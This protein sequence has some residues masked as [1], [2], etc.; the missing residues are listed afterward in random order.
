MQRANFSGDTVTL[1]RDDHSSDAH[2]APQ[3]SEALSSVHPPANSDGAPR[4]PETSQPSL[5]PEAGPALKRKFLAM[6]FWI[7]IGVVTIATVGLV[8]AAFLT[9]NLIQDAAEA[10]KSAEAK[11]TTAFQDYGEALKNYDS[12]AEDAANTIKDL[13]ATDLGTDDTVG[14]TRLSAAERNI[15]GADEVGKVPDHKRLTFETASNEELEAETKRLHLTVKSLESGEWRYEQAT[16]TLTQAK[17]E[18]A[19]VEAKARAAAELAAKKAAAQPVAYED[20]FRAGES[21]R[22][23][24][25]VF[26]GKIIQ[27]AGSGTYRVSITQ[28]PG[29]SRVFWEDPILV[30]VTGTPSQRLLEDDLIYFV[31]LSMGVESYKSV[32][33]QEISLPLV[34]TT[35]TE[36][37][38]TGRDG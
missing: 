37:T 28:K 22:G 23:N 29:Y 13:T 17:A 31:G 21:A 36:I 27:D 38:I 20:L 10:R 26:E 2:S 1:D 4:S 3:D 35:G 8:F 11:Y 14:Q 7:G 34:S 9:L 15:A 33:G 5:L 24:Y 16:Q 32:L 6:P 25:Y 19:E 12:A 18:R 30:A